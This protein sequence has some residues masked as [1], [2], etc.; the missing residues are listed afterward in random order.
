MADAN[1]RHAECCVYPHGNLAYLLGLR[2]NRILPGIPVRRGTPG[3]ALR[4][5]SGVRL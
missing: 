1:A 4:D 5:A 3:T 2:L